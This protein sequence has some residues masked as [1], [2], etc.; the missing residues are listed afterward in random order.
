MD[1]GE[2][3]VE[4]VYDVG[5]LRAELGDRLGRVPTDDELLSAVAEFKELHIEL[6][7]QETVWGAMGTACDRALEKEV[8]E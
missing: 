1:Y 2:N 5:Y 8:P 7:L 3:L 4:L 6:D